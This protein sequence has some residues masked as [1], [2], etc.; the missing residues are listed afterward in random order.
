[1]VFNQQ[2]DEGE[3]SGVESPPAGEEQTVPAGHQVT[4]AE[5]VMHPKGLDV[6]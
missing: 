2:A 1:M 4:Q 5:N 6:F 3:T